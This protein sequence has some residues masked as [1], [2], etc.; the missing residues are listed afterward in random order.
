MGRG[1]LAIV[2][3][4]GISGGIGVAMS[5][6]AAHGSA[7]PLLEAGAKLLLLHA[8]A[9]VAIAALAAALPRSGGM[10]LGSAALLLGGGLVFCADMAARGFLGSRLFPMAAPLGGTLLILGWAWLAIAAL[11]AAARKFS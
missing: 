5:G 6:I 2:A 7:G 1:I 3:L 4:S 9:A 10:F 8:V 11:V